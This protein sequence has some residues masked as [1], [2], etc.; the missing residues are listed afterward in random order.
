ML[1]RNKNGGDLIALKIMKKDIGFEGATSD[2]VKNEVEIMTKLNH[3]NI[4]NLLEF[5]D[6]A[7]HTKANGVKTPVYYL[8]LELANGG[9]LFDFIAQTGK[10]SEDIA[11]F[12]FHQLVDTF[13]YLHGNGVSHRDIKPENIMLDADFNLKIADFGFSS[14]KAVNESL[15]GTNSYM[16]PEILLGNKYSGQCVDLFAAGVVL[17]I[18]VA[19]HQP[20]NRA[21]SQDT[22]YKLL[23]NKL[24]LFWKLHSRNKPNGLDFFT[25]EFRDFIPSILNFDPI[26]RPSLAEVKAS[27]WYNGPVPTYDQVRNEFIERKQA[28]DDANMQE[29]QD[30]PSEEVD[31]SVFT[32]GTVHRGVGGELED[33]NTLPS[34]ER[35]CLEYSPEFKRYS[36]FFS[37]SELEPL[38]NTL[39][40]FA[41]RFTTEYEFSADDYSA[42]VSVLQ[43]EIKV[44]M[45]VNILKVDEN[46]YCIEAVKN[47]GERFVFNEIYNKMKLF[48]GGHANATETS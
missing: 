47:S 27:E 39:A 41:D 46:K 37:K 16:A 45:T 17:F 31:P 26:Q 34:L 18:M 40:L 24:D 3:P 4:I 2:V 7:E 32:N 48:F 1:A 13:E 5:S 29:D 21:S 43:D 28:M 44:S 14:N 6:T 30:F 20:F 22:H 35:F 12:Y 42:T 15:K 10:F 8:A 38:F 23:T 25:K 19:Q 33:D 9:E 11:R 36:Q